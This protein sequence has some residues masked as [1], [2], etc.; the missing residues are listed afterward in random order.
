M[1]RNYLKTTLH[2]FKR[3]KS[4]AFINVFGFA[5]GIAVCLLIVLYVHHEMSYD[6]F[7]EKAD[8]LYRV[9][10]QDSTGE[11]SSGTQGPMGPAMTRS[12]PAVEEAVRL[13][14]RDKTLVRRGTKHF[15][16]EN[17]LRADSTFFEVFTFPLVHGDPHTALR[18]PDAIVL[19]ASMAE[20]FF[21]DENPVGR[22]LTLGTG[23]PRTVTGVAQ[24]VSPN[25][26]I[27]FDYVVPMPDSLHG[28]VPISKWNRFSGFDTY[29]LLKRGHVPASVEAGLPA[30]AETHMNKK[31]ASE[32]HFILQPLRDIH[33]SDLGG[34]HPRYLY[35][36]STI[37][38]LI[39]LIACINYVNLA[40]ARS[41]ERAREVGVRRAVGAQRGQVARQFL[42]ESLLLCGV[43]LVVAVGLA[44]ALL[45][46]FSALIGKEI[47]FI[48]SGWLLA[49]FA[50]AVLGVGLLAGLYP[51]LFLSSFQPTD[52]LR[53]RLERCFSGGALR[54]GL[55]V[56]QF[57]VSVTLIAGTAVVFQQLRYVQTK[58]LGLDEEQVLVIPLESK[59]LQERYPTVKREFRALP[60][61]MEVT[62]ASTAL[63]QN[64]AMTF[65]Q[66]EGTDERQPVRFI[67][68]APNF[69]EVLGIERTAGRDF[70]KKRDDGAAIL[71]N[72]AAV[73]EF[74]WTEPLG[75]SIPF[76]RRQQ[77]VVGV[78]KNFHF[79]SMREEIAPLM[80]VPEAESADYVMARLDAGSHVPSTLESLEAA[81]RQFGSAYPFAYSFLD[82]DYGAFYR[83]ERRTGRVLAVFAGLAVLIAALGLFG[84][85]AFAAE[86]RSQE[87]A[88]RKSFGASARQVVQLLSKDFLKLVGIGFLIAVPLGWYAGQ[89]WLEGFAYRI[90]LGPWTFLLTGALALGVAAATVSTQALRAART[91][92]AQALRNE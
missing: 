16:V 68:V 32:Q 78:V 56:F 9:V 42:G 51:A 67:N 81:Y 1:L 28:S 73:R 36:F 3:Q 18:T 39:L 25:S 47:A 10:S 65:T 55:V 8:R 37:A 43:A 12:F 13:Y 66:P 83:A 24:D 53:G 38:A 33:L 90:E 59:S 4:Y 85:A 31:R 2:T 20:K 87:I 60:A 6:A 14:E 22:T 49:S 92:P 40:T 70:S 84:L 21:G 71:I 17:G 61:V 86:A 52:V 26:H 15:Y 7:H 63:A 54:K 62:G 89:R 34:G 58:K 44:R 23:E 29:L 64:S 69:T 80:L 79:A 50:G 76:G 48:Q 77:R 57:A 75:K 91:N 46:V 30:F 19:T 35:V 41:A 5:V 74:G 27:S 72:E 88:I 45:P 82:E 11:R